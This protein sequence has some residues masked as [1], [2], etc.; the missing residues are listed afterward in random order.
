M[1]KSRRCGGAASTIEARVAGLSVSINRRRRSVLAAAMT[2]LPG[3]ALA[4]GPGAGRLVL[5]A[6]GDQAV[7]A[8]A[9]IA[10]PGGAERLPTVAPFP[11]LPPAEVRRFSVSMGNYTDSLKLAEII[12]QLSHGDGRYRLE[13]SGQATGLVALVYSGEL[14]QSSEGSVSPAGLMPEHYREKRGRRPERSLRF[15]WKAGVMIGQG[16]P[17]EVRLPPGTQDR[18]SLAYQLGLMARSDSRLL[19]AGT[20]FALPLAAMREIE[21]VAITS[22]GSTRLRINGGDYEAVKF[23]IRGERHADD[24]IDVWLAPAQAMLPI[25]IRFAEGGG[26]VIDQVQ[27][28]PRS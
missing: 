9:G 11:P 24:R 13:T 21:D 20:R 17:P 6:T 2:I 26:K 4:S 25:R 15:D 19:A 10:I 14:T 28:M 16:D 5:A 23:E 18:L 1:C 7:S 22:T 12:Y 3:T 8:G 27:V